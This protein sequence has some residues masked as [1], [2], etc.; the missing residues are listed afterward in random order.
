M[1]IRTLTLLSICTVALMACRGPQP[2]VQPVPAATDPSATLSLH[3]VDAV[4]WQNT[5]AEAYRLYQQC[6]E[7]ARIR[8]DQRL[9][10][11]HGLPPAVL[12]DVDETVLD[13]SPYEM[14]SIALGRTFSD[15]T[16]KQW[17]D[18]AS[19]RALPGA[20][21]FLQYAASRECEVFY[22]TNRSL[23]EKE[24]TV[25]NLKAL[26]FPFADRNHVMARE[27][28][29][30]KSVRRGQLAMDYD[31]KL[32][33]G[34]QLRDFDEVFNDRSVDMGR[35]QVDALRDTLQK[36]FI[37]LPNPMYGTW[38]DVISGKGTD[39]E[40]EKAIRRFLDQQGR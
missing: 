29:S 17:T 22:I 4:L 9:E 5:S 33:V 10:H 6:F 7:L 16:W 2:V 36:Y 19:A 21:E 35:P 1:K 20:L 40:K 11:I 8:L 34:D 27:A 12:V 37:L 18:R 39:A 3:A 15:S 28:S 30:D 23:P 13:N 38:R 31:I 25:R 24:A 32:L 26:G 14:E